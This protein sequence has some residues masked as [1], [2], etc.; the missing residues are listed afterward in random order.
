M[1]RAALYARVSTDDKGQST[2]NQLAQ[3]RRFAAAQGWVL[4]NEYVDHESGAKANRPQFRAM[5]EAASRREFDVLLFWS[6]DRLSR[7]GALKTLQTLTQLTDW[8]VAY[9]SF[10]EPYLDS[11]GIFSDAIV[12]LL[13]TLADQIEVAVVRSAICQLLEGQE[14]GQL[15]PQ[16]LNATVVALLAVVVEEYLPPDLTQLLLEQAKRFRGISG[17]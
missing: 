2:E 4:A 13:A 16:F 5:M 11:A 14:R 8:G 15:G 3:L 6:L 10:T 7:E 12:A 9:R 1:T 17:D